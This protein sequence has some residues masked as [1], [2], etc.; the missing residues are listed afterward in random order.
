MERKNGESLK[1]SVTNGTGPGVRKSP[2]LQRELVGLGCFLDCGLRSRNEQAPFRVG[3]RAPT[4]MPER[5]R[6][7]ERERVWLGL[8]SGRGV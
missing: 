3:H 6:E 5:E 2:R 4:R 8:W 7:R 1:R